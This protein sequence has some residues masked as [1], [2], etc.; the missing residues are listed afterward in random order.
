MAESSITLVSK[1]TLQKIFGQVSSH[2][3][4]V[5]KNG[6]ENLT[7]VTRKPDKNIFVKWF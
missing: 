2:F 6:D 4:Q 5:F 1:T 3:G 7:V